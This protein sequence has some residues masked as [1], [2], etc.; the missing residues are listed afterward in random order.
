MVQFG[1]VWLGLA[2][3]HLVSKPFSLKKQVLI[4]MVYHV[5]WLYLCWYLASRDYLE[6]CMNLFMLFIC[7][8]GQIPI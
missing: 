2:S 6:A 8:N 5:L 7:V 1:L 3:L 4:K